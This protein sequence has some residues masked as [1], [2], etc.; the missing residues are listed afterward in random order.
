MN[1]LLK[2]SI[3]MTPMLHL[4]VISS[5]QVKAGLLVLGYHVYVICKVANSLAWVIKFP[6]FF[7]NFF[8]IQ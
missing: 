6:D 8:K 7:L 4:L 2:L 3:A 1:Y 5:K